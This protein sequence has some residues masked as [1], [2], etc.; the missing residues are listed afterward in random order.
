MRGLILI[1]FTISGLVAET[2]NISGQYRDL[3]NNPIESARVTYHQDLIVVD[4]TLTNSSGYFN[5]SIEVV[6]VDPVLP[7][8][9]QLGQNYPNPFN[10][11]TRIDV[12]IQE[13]GTFSIYD[14]RGALIESADLPAA[15]R[16]ELTW[17][18]GNLGAG[19]YVYVLKSGYQSASKKMILLDGG[20]GTGLYSKHISQGY[21]SPLSKPASN[22]MIR[23]VKENTSGSEISFT[24]PL[25]DTS[26]GV[27]QGNVGPVLVQEIPDIT[28]YEG[29]SLGLEWN[30]Y[31]YND[32]E[33]QYIE[34]VGVIVEDGYNL[35]V[36]A[37]D[38]MDSSLT[39]SS[40]LFMV[41]VNDENREPIETD[42]IPD[43]V[44]NE[45]E[46]VEIMLSDHFMDPDG[47]SLIY[48]FY[49]PEELSTWTLSGDT[50][51]IIPN[52]DMNESLEIWYSITDG[53]F[54]LPGNIIITINP[55]DDLP[56][57]I[58]PLPNLETTSGTPVGINLTSHVIEVDGETLTYTVNL[59]TN[60]WIVEGD[61]LTFIHP[62]GF[63]GSYE[64][65]II[66][67][68]DGANNLPLNAI[69]V[70]VADTP[71]VHF[72]I[73]DFQTDSTLAGETTTFT[74][75][76]V[77]HFTT[78]GELDLS[79]IEGTYD[80]D[81]W[82]PIAWYMFGLKR[83]GDIDN[84]DQYLNNTDE[85][86][87][88]TI[89]GDDTI[90][91]YKVLLTFPLNSVAPYI[92]HLLNGTVRFATEDLS[93]PA[94]YDLNYDP[95]YPHISTEMQNFLQIALPDATLG[96][97]TLQYEEG[98]GEP[99]T[100]HLWMSIDPDH[101]TPG[102][103]TTLYNENNE[104]TQARARWSSNPIVPSEYQV[105]IEILQS[106]GDF[107]DLD[108]TDPPF[109]SWN[110][111][112]GLY[113]NEL[114]QNALSLLYFLQPGTHIYAPGMAPTSSEMMREHVIPYVK[115]HKNE[116]G[117]YLEHNSPRLIEL[118]YGQELGLMNSS[119]E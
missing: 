33:T 74:I 10:P 109:I 51:R 114:G 49:V 25:A 82:S 58:A 7:A 100:N 117:T 56:R 112:Q 9:F 14:I 101:P 105:Q 18:G 4:S 45:D 3:L 71:I 62:E 34:T 73:K 70:V 91:V 47:D 75:D 11:S 24:T 68:H 30:D 42:S 102:V 54:Y 46:L 88:F 60:L 77:D 83:P 119:E 78:T 52:P 115:S 20:D 5:L 92:D 41:T 118:G 26:V 8:G 79:L 29:D 36:T 12:S 2:I 44:I 81:V 38:L 23:F 76:G 108:G 89:T 61:S 99:D 110:E 104:I 96:K 15:G 116:L 94:R 19:L 40:N 87:Q 93:A 28:I 97:L 39:S 85:E 17:G 43:Y 107:P 66:S 84:F 80:I 48:Y 67:A 64:D 113:I 27:I 55:V 98:Y 16:F 22:D 13:P 103:N 35:S 6:S 95:V 50:A 53:E 37:T 1:I 72:V 106:I 86:C 21:N 90:Q 31:F 59:S 69:D 57:Q 32:S 65:V 111:D 63:V